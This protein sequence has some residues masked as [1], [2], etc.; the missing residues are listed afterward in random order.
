MSREQVAIVVPALLVAALLAV[1]VQ[2]AA[3][4]E[5]HRPKATPGS[6]LESVVEPAAAE[7]EPAAPGGESGDP[8]EPELT[9]LGW[10]GR[11]HPP[12]VHFPIALLLS[13]VASEF[14]G[15]ASG[16]DVF[17][18]STRFAVWVGALGACVA[19]PLGWLF[20]ETSIAGDEWLMAAHRWAGTAVA[21]WAL[22]TLLLCERAQ[23]GIGSVAAFRAALV[24]S[25][26]LVGAAGFLGGSL[27]YG[28]DHLEW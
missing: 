13:A 25:A 15:A 22:P 27:V 8:S 19:A 24:L 18:H 7:F 4:H 1:G 26:A 21:V 14:L 12:S 6:D 3:A 10:L 16:R 23:R 5:G 20:S 28:I 17:R 11:L 2:T 9:F